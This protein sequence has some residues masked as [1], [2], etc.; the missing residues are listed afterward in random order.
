[1]RIFA[2]LLAPPCQ[3][4]LNWCSCQRNEAVEEGEMAGTW[5]LPIPR[6][7]KEYKSGFDVWLRLWRVL[8]R[9]EDPSPNVD[10]DDDGRHTTIKPMKTRQRRTTCQGHGQVRPRTKEIRS[11]SHSS[12]SEVPTRPTQRWRLLQRASCHDPYKIEI[13]VS[14]KKHLV[15]WYSRPTYSSVPLYKRIY[16]RIHRNLGSSAMLVA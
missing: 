7:G 16:G 6:C 11:R 13:V 14:T 5:S 15:A 9:E 4:S 3:D 8:D 1:M 10:N 2:L 12:S